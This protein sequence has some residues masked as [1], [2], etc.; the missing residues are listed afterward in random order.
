M[1]IVFP[2]VYFC[3]RILKKVM[4][5]AQNK[6]TQQSASKGEI[7]VCLLFIAMTTITSTATLWVVRS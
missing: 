6:Y 5:T 7:A 3:L 1:Q 2:K 4:I